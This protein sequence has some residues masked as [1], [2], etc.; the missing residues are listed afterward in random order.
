MNI[1]EIQV[2]LEASEIEAQDI[3]ESSDKEEIVTPIFNRFQSPEDSDS[4]LGLDP[5]LQVIPNSTD[6]TPGNYMHDQGKAAGKG[7]KN[8][9]NSATRTLPKR[10]IRL[11]LNKVPWIIGGDFNTML[12][13]HENRRGTITSLGYIEDINDM[14]LDSGLTDAGF[15]GKSFTWSNKKDQA[16]VVANEVEKQ[17]HRPS[18]ANLINLNKQNATL[19]NALNLESEFWRQKATANGLKQE[20][21]HQIFSF[22]GIDSALFR[23]ILRDTSGTS[24]PHDFPFQFPQVHQNVVLNLC[25]PPSQEDIKEVVFSINKDSVARPDG[26]SSAFFQACWNIIVED[27]IAA[28]TDFFRGTPMP[29]SF[30]ATSIILIPKNDSPQSWLIA[31][32]IFFAQE[33]THLLDMRHSKGNL[34]LKLDMYKAYDRVKWKFLYA[35]L[36]KMGFPARF[37]TLIKRAIEHC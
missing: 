17:F 1:I 33:M 15:E 8:K 7:K 12:H 10:H 18:E 32:N 11:S 34:I 35:I 28:I 5:E 25:Q 21:E 26:F 27:V 24:L 14:V 30:I 37:I 4:L 2:T 20:K 31:N 23:S 22:L 29:R 19:V 6:S 16:K 36:E 9:G 13:K 3:Q